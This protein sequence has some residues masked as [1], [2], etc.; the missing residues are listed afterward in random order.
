MADNFGLE[1]SWKRLHQKW[2]QTKSVW[3]DPVSRDF[4]RKLMIP[5]AE[6]ELRTQRELECLAQVVE[7]A[8]RNVR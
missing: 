5:L 1:G 8:R 7:Q 6:Q 4:E 3:D 2:E